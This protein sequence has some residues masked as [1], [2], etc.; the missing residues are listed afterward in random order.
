MNSN[1]VVL[2]R[3]LQL[4]LENNYLNLNVQYVM[5]I[6]QGYITHSVYRLKVMASMPQTKQHRELG[7]KRWKNLRHE[8]LVRDGYICW[9]CGGDGAD[10]VDH[11]VARAEGGDIWDRDNLA[12]AHKICNSRKG[13]KAFFSGSKATDR[14]STRLNSSH[15]SVSRM[16]SSA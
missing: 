1:A 13:K 4:V 6:W 9:I 12:A 16:P 14:K 11:L 7:T 5:V 3:K 10:S 8:I 15:S 2:H